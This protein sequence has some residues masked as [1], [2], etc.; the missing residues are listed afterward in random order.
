MKEVLSKQEV[1]DWKHNQVT[2]NFFAGLEQSK[3]DIF[4]YITAGGVVRD[5]TDGTAQELAG[6][7]GKLSAIRDILNFTIEDM[8]D[9]AYEEGKDED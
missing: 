2:L 3:Q 1:V 9:N 6:E 8:I 7:L 5:S 4:E